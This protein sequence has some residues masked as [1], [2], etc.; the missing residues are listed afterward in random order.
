MRARLIIY[1]F[2]LILPSL[3]FAQA[4]ISDSLRTEKLHGLGTAWAKIKYF[5]PYLAYRPINW[6]SALVQAIPKVVNAKDGEEYSLAVQSMLDALNDPLTKV[7]SRKRT[8]GNGSEIELL[9][10]RWVKDS[11]LVVSFNDYRELDNYETSFE[12]FG[13]ICPLTLKAKGVVFD[14]RCLINSVDES[15]GYIDFVFSQLEIQNR[16]SAA[17]LTL[18]SHR[19]L[20]YSMFQS[21]KGSTVN[22]Y[23]AFLVRQREQITPADGAMDKPIIFLIN[24]ESDLPLVAKSLQRNGLAKIYFVGDGHITL[25]GRTIASELTDPYYVRLRVSEVI[26][27][28]GSIDIMPDTI[29]SPETDFMPFVIN[30]IEHFVVIDTGYVRSETCIPTNKMDSYSSDSA[31]PSREYRLLAAFKIWAVFNYFFPYKNLMGEDWDAVLR[32]SL[33]KFWDAANAEEYQDAVMEMTAFV[34]DS[35]VNIDWPGRRIELPMFVCRYIENKLTVIKVFSDS[36]RQ[37]IQVGDEVVSIDGHSIA[38][39]ENKWRPRIS[40]ST[41]QAMRRSL[42]SRYFYGDDGSEIAL[43]LRNDKTESKTITTTRSNALRREMRKGWRDGDIFT[44]I[45]PEIGYADLERLEVSQVDSMF[46]MFENTEAVIFDLRGYP[47]GT[48]WRITPI[49]NRKRSKVITAIADKPMVFMDELTDANGADLHF[50]SYATMFEENKSTYSGKVVVLIDER[51][52]SQSEYSCLSFEAAAD[53]TFIGTATAGACGDVVYF[54]I[55]GNISVMMSGI[56]TR[57][58]DGRQLQ[59]IGVIP[60]I[61]IAPTVEGIRS[62]RDEVLERAIEFINTGK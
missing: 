53:V 31:F 22:G 46:K 17:T 36:L 13:E 18:P 43:E 5:H 33:S 19:S 24:E 12:S 48:A 1:V 27:D 54:S 7:M 40:A 49:L 47:K 61:E 42:P 50:S 55:P 9:S 4:N 39:L 29:L 8:T 34:H 60:D 6:D 14:L 44:L 45:T 21:E 25:P 52:I 35:H 16:L 28:D 32:R 30:E 3:S 11:I 2:V 38:S 15:T 56:S 41:E 20:M 23:S 10:F 62:G 58:A 26:S 37:D 59:R 51:A 57:Y